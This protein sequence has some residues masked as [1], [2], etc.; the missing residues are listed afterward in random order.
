ML[1]KV[2]IRY[3]SS[4]THFLGHTHMLNLTGYRKSKEQ[5]HRVWHMVCGTRRLVYWLGYEKNWK[6]APINTLGLMMN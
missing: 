2:D 6:S 1:R 4:P 3:Y 5:S